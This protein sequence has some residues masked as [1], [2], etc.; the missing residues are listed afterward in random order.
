M[1]HKRWTSPSKLVYMHV[2]NIMIWKPI[3]VRQYMSNAL[4]DNLLFDAISMGRFLFSLKFFL[5][6][7]P[8]LFLSL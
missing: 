8:S 5:S 6:L 2:Y 1:L 3:S 7:S 4:N